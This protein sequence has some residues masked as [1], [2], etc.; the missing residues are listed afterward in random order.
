MTVYFDRIAKVFGLVVAAL[1]LGLAGVS[2]QDVKQ[3]KLTDAQVTNF[4]KAQA[5][6]ASIASKIQAAGEKPDPALQTELEGIA[7]KHGFTDFAELDDVAANISIVMAGLDT[8]SGNFTDPVEALQKELED[9][10]KDESIPEADKKQLVD[11]L[12]EAIKTTPPLQN[13]ENIDVVKTHR[14]EIEKALQ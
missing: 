11:E 10:K 3:I 12:T 1:W 2:A 4:I 13:K 6:L 7:K 9:V 5:D 8:Q 14:A